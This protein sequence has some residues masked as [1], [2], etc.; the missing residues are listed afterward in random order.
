MLFRK[1]INKL[2]TK[3]ERME[4]IKILI[5]DDHKM[6]REGLKA[7]LSS[8]PDFTIIGEASDGHET[9][10]KVKEL[11]P[12]IVLMDISMPNL[13]GL[14]ATRQ[15]RRKFPKTKV[16][17]LTMHLNEEYIFQSLQLGASGYLLKENAAEDLISAIRSV[18]EGHSYLSPSISKA[19]IDAYLRKRIT[20]KGGSPFE[21]LT[22]REREILQMIA[23]GNT[24]KEIGKKLFISTKT[25]E[26]HRA[27][28]MNKLDIHEV[29]KLVKFA[30]K[31]GL[32]DLNA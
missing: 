23:E 17:I 25:V 8:Q 14:E 15:I 21:I 11:E 6:V 10:K 5:A 2:K 16:L 29:A 18:Q 19:V 1:R 22:A 12:D 28:I 24:N 3:G 7:L 27:H 13:N 31:N 32:I 9:V 30:I 4:E 20:G 26:A